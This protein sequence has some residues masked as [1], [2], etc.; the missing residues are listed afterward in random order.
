MT[1]WSVAETWT[2]RDHSDPPKDIPGMPRD[3][4]GIP[5]D[6]QGVQAVTTKATSSCI[7]RKLYD[8]EGKTYL[9][10]VTIKLTL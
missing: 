7:L 4:P 1:K 5:Q 8:F 10:T 3:P 2:P 9:C 6:L